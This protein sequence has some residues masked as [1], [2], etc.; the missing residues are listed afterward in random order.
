MSDNPYATPSA[1]ASADVPFDAVIAQP[2]F[3]A[4]SITK[5]V[6]MS[7]CTFGM[8]ELYW[9]YQNWKRVKQREGTNIVPWARAFFGIF[10]CYALFEH[11]RDFDSEGGEHADLAAGPLAA[12][13]II[14]TLLSRLPDPYWLVSLAA[15]VFVVPVQL[16]MN[17]INATMVPTHDPNARFSAANWV[18]AVLGAILCVLGVAG[19]FIT[20]R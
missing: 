6:V 1:F 17:E 8:Y 9:F 3:F 18:G 7:I 4:V 11:V 19:T 14:T 16:Q 5:L 12:G 2:P 10:F 15:V 13:W 20:G